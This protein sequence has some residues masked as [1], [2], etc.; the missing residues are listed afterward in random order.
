MTES[1]S[2]AELAESY[3]RTEDLSAFDEGEEIP[4][5]VKRNVTI[6]VRFS[7]D[8]I[9]DLRTRAEQAG[10]KVT[11]LIRA[12]ALESDGPVDLDAVREVA[13]DLKERAQELAALAGPRR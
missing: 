4:V 11:S 2:E 13:S 8:E 5:K 7:E 3:N 12:A 10:V 1:M 9:R 6:S